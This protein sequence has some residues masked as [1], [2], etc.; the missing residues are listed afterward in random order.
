MRIIPP[1]TALALPAQ[2]IQCT[3]GNSTRNFMDLELDVEFYGT[4]YV[5]EEC[6]NAWFNEWNSPLIASLRRELGAA[7]AEIGAL[8]G[9]EHSLLSVIRAYDI[10]EP[11][12]AGQLS[13]STEETAEEHKRPRRYPDDFNESSSKPRSNDLLGSTSK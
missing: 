9:L 12:L 10:P 7:Q 11:N 5:C 2:C 6:F 13:L 4:V 3:S 1:G 8:R